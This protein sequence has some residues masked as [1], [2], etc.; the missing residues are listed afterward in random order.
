MGGLSQRK[1]GHH[2]F[3]RLRLGEA[4]SSVL[5]GGVGGYETWIEPT[6]P[7]PFVA[8]LLTSPGPHVVVVW[9]GSQG[10]EASWDGRR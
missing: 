2:L 3:S 9:Q 4:A 8:L 7:G 6:R 1:G 10:Q 5:R